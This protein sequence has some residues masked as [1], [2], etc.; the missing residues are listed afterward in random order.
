MNAILAELKSIVTKPVEV[1]KI[2]T[3]K[4]LISHEQRIAEL[5]TAMQ[6]LAASKVTRED[7]EKWIKYPHQDYVPDRR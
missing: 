7:V 4:T 1:R 3:H 2:I 5:E 6:N